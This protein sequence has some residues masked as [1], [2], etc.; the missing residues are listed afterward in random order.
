MVL[1]TGCSVTIIS[2]ELAARLEIDPDHTRPGLARVADGRGV[3]ARIGLIDRITVG[4]GSKTFLEVGI[5][6]NPGPADGLL[7][8]NF[9][10]DFRY[11]MDFGR[12]QIDW[13]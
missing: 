8:M 10:R 3:A 5:M 13:R 1:D 7:G 4:P 9:L 11:R 2:E 6:S 12:Q